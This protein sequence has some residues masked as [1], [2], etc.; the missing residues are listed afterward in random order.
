MQAPAGWPQHQQRDAGSQ[1]EL[2][3]AL[4]GLTDFSPTSIFNA[5]LN[6]IMK[7]MSPTVNTV[8]SDLSKPHK[9]VCLFLNKNGQV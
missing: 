3:A 4:S 7:K 1:E 9:S 6:T 2:C 8:D 5:G